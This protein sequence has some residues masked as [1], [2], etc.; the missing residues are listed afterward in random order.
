MET[1]FGD[2]PVLKTL[3]SCEPTKTGWRGVDQN[4]AVYQVTYQDAQLIAE[5]PPENRLIVSENG[6]AVGVWVARAQARPGPYPGSQG[7]PVAAAFSDPLNAFP[8]RRV[9]L[10]CADNYHQP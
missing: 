5:I 3:T 2:L 10:G 8:R 9:P 1:S 7:G 4:G 6:Y